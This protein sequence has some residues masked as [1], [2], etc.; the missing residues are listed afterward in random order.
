[1]ETAI[2]AFLRPFVLFVL[3]IAILYPSRKAVEKYMKEGALKRFF[4]RRDAKAMTL[5]VIVGYC[6]IGLIGFIIYSWPA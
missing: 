5:G 6:V 2:A 4:L 3:A 1:M